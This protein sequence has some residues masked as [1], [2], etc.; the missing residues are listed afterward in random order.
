MAQRTANVVISG[1][2][3]NV[4]YRAWTVKTA[5]S[6]G[7]SGWVRNR[8][9]GTVEAVFCGEESAV[10]MMLQDC[11]DGPPAARVTELEVSDWSEPVDSGFS[12]K[13][14]L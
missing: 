1:K 14:T 9:D 5:Q 13:P 2:V 6:H 4:W 8:S 11:Q 3:Q 12:E 10:E 7:L